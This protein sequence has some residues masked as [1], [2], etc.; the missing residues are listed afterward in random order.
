MKILQHN[1]YMKTIFSSGKGL[2]K[3][4]TKKCSFSSNASLLLQRD[5]NSAPSKVTGLSTRSEDGAYTWNTRN[6][7]PVPAEDL[8]STKKF[9][10]A[11]AKTRKTKSE[12][13][14]NKIAEYIIRGSMKK[15]KKITSEINAEREKDIQAVNRS[16]ARDTDDFLQNLDKKVLIN[17]YYDK[18]IKEHNRSSKEKFQNLMDSVITYKELN[19]P[20][21]RYHSCFLF[22][23]FD[24]NI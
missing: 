8:Y 23:D 18:Q 4:F 14:V 13:R 11:I 1:L 22:L 15:E 6:P 17:W 3:Q 9:F 10:R 21:Y 19:I 20:Q 5:N 2:Y 16:Y 7:T 24:E 12:N